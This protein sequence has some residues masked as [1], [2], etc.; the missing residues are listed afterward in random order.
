MSITMT[1][2]ASRLTVLGSGWSN[3]SVESGDG[4]TE[5]GQLWED[6][7][8]D[9]G[10]DFGADTDWDNLSGEFTWTDGNLEVNN[11]SDGVIID[12]EGNTLIDERMLIE[13]VAAL[14][15]TAL[16]DSEMMKYSIADSA[17]KHLF[18]GPVDEESKYDSTDPA[19]PHKYAPPVFYIQISEDQ[20]YLFLDEKFY[21]TNANG[22]NLTVNEK[23]IKI[24][25]GSTQAVYWSSC[26]TH[27]SDN[28]LP[29]GL[30]GFPIEYVCWQ[31][32][33]GSF[34]NVLLSAT[35]KTATIEDIKAGKV[36]PKKVIKNM[37]YYIK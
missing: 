8:G 13:L 17:L 27:F 16:S 14:N 9:L 18:G 35:D 2:G 31:C 21:H 34:S 5:D 7:A 22:G 23:H 33:Y 30:Q 28:Y 12:D 24:R 32:L 29:V 37:T 3:Y 4:L 1:P 19:R 36:Y 11:W 25:S 26:A 15:V 20:A 10:F 6:I